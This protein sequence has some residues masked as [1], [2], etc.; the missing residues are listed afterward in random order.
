MSSRTAGTSVAL[1]A[2]YLIS[3][4]PMIDPKSGARSS[5]LVDADKPIAEWT[6]RKSFDSVGQC[7][8]FRNDWTIE[9]RQAAEKLPKPLPAPTLLELNTRAQSKCVASDDPRF[10]K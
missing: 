5:E 6:I 7:Q 10:L 3:P 9:A 1:F 8:A 4:Q 2:W